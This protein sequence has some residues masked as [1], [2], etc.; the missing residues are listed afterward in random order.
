MLCV[1]RYLLHIR[2]SLL[3]TVP[4]KSVVF[5]AMVQHA[6]YFAKF[7]EQVLAIPIAAILRFSIAASFAELVSSGTF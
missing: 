3:L 5:L 1:D 4:Y 7:S 2:K 6:S